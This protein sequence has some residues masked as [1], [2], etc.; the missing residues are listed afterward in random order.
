MSKNG[1]RARPYLAL[2]LL[3]TSLMVVSSV[4][5][6]GASRVTASSHR[7]APLI[8]ADPQADNTDLYAFVSPDAPDTVT[9]IASFYPGQDPAGGP[10]F[11]RF[12]DDVFYDIKIDRDGDAVEDLVYQF[13]FA[14][15][16]QNPNTFL[17]NTGP[18]EVQED[19]TP[20]ADPDY[21]LR[22]LYGVTEFRDGERRQLT[23]GLIVPPANIG[24]ASTP[25]YESLSD[26]G[27]Y[28]IDEDIK[29]FAGPSDDPFWVDL[30]GIFD[31]L[32]IRTPPGNQGGG[33]DDLAGLNVLTIAMQ[34]PIEKLT[35][36]GETPEAPDSANAIIG[37]WS[38]T[39]RFS[40]T[41]INADGT[42]DGE[43]DLVQ[44]SRLGHPLVNEVVV[45][46]GAKDLFNASVPADDGQ[47]LDG[48]L[49]PELPG[50]LNALYGI[51][52]PEG[53]RNDLVAIY[54]TGIPGINQP[55]DVVASEQLRLNMAIPP[56]APD[57]ASPLGA[58]GGDPAGFPNGRRLEDEVVDISLRVV[59]GILFGEDGIA[60][61]SE[62]N[63]EPN[64]QLGD[65]VDTNDVP[66]RDA[67][68]YVALAHAGFEHTHHGG[69]APAA[70]D[71]GDD[72]DEVSTPAADDED[73][74]AEDGDDSD[75]TPVVQA[76]DVSKETGP[77]TIPLGELND[78]GTSGVA[79][80]EETDE[81][82]S[83]NLYLQGAE[84]GHP[85]H[86]HQGTC[87]E[88]DPNPQYPLLDVDESG[89][90]VTVI[91][92]LAL[93]D[94]LNDPYAVNIHLSNEDVATYITCGNVVLPE[95]SEEEATS[96]GVTLAEIDGSGVS[97]EAVL[98]DQEDGL[99]VN[100]YLDGAS[101]GHPAHIHEGTCAELDPNPEY[102]LPDVDENGLSEQ[103]IEGVDT[104]ELLESPH[105]VN[106]HLSNDEIGTYIACGN[107]VAA[108]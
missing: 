27:I 21:N 34:I 100:L 71:D 10:N 22:Q 72:A 75:A 70:D 82:L 77:I 55:P 63:V 9:L 89:R 90:S 60:L 107:I 69:A 68:P 81:G 65:G 2:G 78:S 12:G 103:S 64:N 80:L 59:A 91:P 44:V 51:E 40:T 87:N 84:G 6:S 79:V 26:A 53:E 16:I 18:I 4:F 39:N 104:A 1:Y 31:L 101:G 38:T 35:I 96:V 97:G 46:V 8:S 15:G 11:Y 42:R 49:N 74:D 105:A 48:V 93:T 83:V 52:V 17:Y 98:S 94:L 3:V 62:F 76:D 58:I 61:D 13:D 106:I 50:L 37:V 24:P 86:I 73:E 19:T 67:F 36:D 45:P 66:F 88:L 41:V 99:L 43:G 23:E 102:P 56:T 108:E 7:E 28:T 33:V 20:L 47:F 14:T 5:N 54:L 57:A 92:D 25:D 32:T 30:G 29:V 95:D 85:A